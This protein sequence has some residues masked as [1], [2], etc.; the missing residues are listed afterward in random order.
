MDTFR[1]EILKAPILHSPFGSLSQ[2]KEKSKYPY[3]T[4]SR[5]KGK[6]FISSERNVN[7]P[8]LN[9]LEFVT[10]RPFP[11]PLL[12]IHLQEKASNLLSARYY[13]LCRIRRDALVYGHAFLLLF[14]LPPP[15]FLRKRGENPGQGGR[16]TEE[17]EGRDGGLS[18]EL[19]DVGDPLSFNQRCSAGFF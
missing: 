8:V 4:T 7:E 10:S 14:F 15:L 9:P 11:Y 3:H 5:E 13:A 18:W 6:R 12:F 19:M 16:K 2:K 17:E 1:K